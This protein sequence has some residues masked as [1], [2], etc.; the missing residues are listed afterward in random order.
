M[1]S[2]YL[3]LWLNLFNRTNLRQHC[4]TLIRLR[5]LDPPSTPRYDF[6]SDERCHDIRYGLQVGWGRDQDGAGSRGE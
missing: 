2:R 3:P 6:R 1:S 5:R 4:S